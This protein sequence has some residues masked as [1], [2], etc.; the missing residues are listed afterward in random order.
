MSRGEDQQPG[1]RVRHSVVVPVLDA[2][3][4]IPQLFGEIVAALEPL[5]GG[6]EVVFVDDGARDRAAECLG[7]CWS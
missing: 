7:R 1:G 5:D 4:S 3:E 6:F 2:A